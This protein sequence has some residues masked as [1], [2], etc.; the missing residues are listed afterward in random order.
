MV[1]NRIFTAWLQQTPRGS[2]IL[3]K[4]VKNEKLLPVTPKILSKS[5]FF[6]AITPCHDVRL[7]PKGIAKLQAASIPPYKEPL[8]KC[9]NR[10][11]REAM[12]KALATV[13]FA[14][15]KARVL[16]LRSIDFLEIW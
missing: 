8:P 10:A 3:I 5:A 6:Q 1:H 12:V 2:A 14:A 7:L 13:M 16:P 9:P 4:Q 11:V 15:G